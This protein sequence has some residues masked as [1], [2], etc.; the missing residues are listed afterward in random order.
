MNHYKNWYKFSL[1]SERKAYGKGFGDLMGIVV[2]T[3]GL[4]NFRRKDR[5]YILRH[6]KEFYE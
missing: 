4:F 3:L 2:G 5:N 6:K 1:K